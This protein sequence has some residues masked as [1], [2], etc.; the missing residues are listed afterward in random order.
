MIREILVLIFISILLAGCITGQAAEKGTLQLT[1]SP[2]GAEIYLDNQYRGSTPSTISD[3]WPGSHTLEFRSGG[4]K[5]WK[6]VISVPA[7]T[8]NYFAALT[9]LPGSEPGTAMSPTATAVVP[10][11]VT[12]RV[13]RERMI[14]GDSNVFSGTAT[15]M[16]TVTLTLSGPGYYSNGITLEQVKPG[17]DDAWSYTWNPGTSIQSGP[18]TIMASDAGKTVSDR[19]HFTAIGDGVVTVTPSSYAIGKGETITLSGRCTTGAPEVSLMLFGPDTF[20]GGVDLGTLS[21][22]ADKTWSFRY[23]TDSAMPTGVYT[24]Y[25]SDV[26]K[27]T[28]GSSQFTI[29]FAS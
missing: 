12:V 19:V 14:V 23:T 17:A 7:G 26:P 2:S 11:T 21:V 28:S 13:S 16:G 18:Y 4:Y 24:I 15:G 8:S 6:A 22:M 10:A 3:V 20:N 25:A 5:S 29:G 9:A 1:S 27:T